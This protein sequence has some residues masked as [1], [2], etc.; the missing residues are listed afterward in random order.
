MGVHALLSVG[1]LPE[2]SVEVLLESVEEMR[3]DDVRALWRLAVA[4]TGVGVDVNLGGL[5][6]NSQIVRVFA[7]LSFLAD[8]GLEVGAEDGLGVFTLLE[9]L[10]L[11]GGDGLEEGLNEGLL[12]LLL[13]LLLLR[14]ELLGQTLVLATPLV[15]LHHLR[16]HLVHIPM[17]K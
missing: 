13:L 12:L 9:L 11:D 14:L 6:F 5:S 15:P 7:F 8:S 10:L 3:A 4:I 16:L 1:A 17:E 2:P